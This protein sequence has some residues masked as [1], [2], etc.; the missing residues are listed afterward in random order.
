M[1]YRAKVKILK[2][3]IVVS[4]KTISANAI[5]DIYDMAIELAGREGISWDA[6]EIVEL[7]KLKD[8]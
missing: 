6:I 2:G 4:G 5:I 1:K 3:S 7:E 8:T